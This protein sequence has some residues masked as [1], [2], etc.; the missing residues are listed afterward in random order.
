MTSHQFSNDE[1]LVHQHCSAIVECLGELCTVTK[2]LKI[3][4]IQVDGHK[5]E[6]SLPTTVTRWPLRVM[7]T[8][9]TKL[10]KAR[11]KQ[12]EGNR[13][14]VRNRCTYDFSVFQ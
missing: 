9:T 10:Y 1:Y 3:Q 4:G 8:V 11:W 14:T 7:H 2:K 5:H 13:V 6:I 12:T